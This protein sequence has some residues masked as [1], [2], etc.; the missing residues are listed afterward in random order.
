M[1]RSNH[2]NLSLPI[3][4]TENCLAMSTKH[5][6]ESLFHQ[7]CPLPEMLMFSQ[8]LRAVI[9]QILQLANFKGHCAVHLYVI[10]EPSLQVYH[11]SMKMEFSLSQNRTLKSLQFK[12]DFGGHLTIVHFNMEAEIL[13]IY[14]FTFKHILKAWLFS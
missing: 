8:Y 11:A 9:V 5:I 1:T 12:I 13:S 14:K 2:I 3:R 4:I 6:M 7:K 10:I